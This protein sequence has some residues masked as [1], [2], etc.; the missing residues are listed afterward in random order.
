MQD[1]R[2]NLFFCFVIFAALGFGCAGIKRPWR[3]YSDKQFSSAEWLVGDKIERGRMVH[4]MFR[5]PAV[6]VGSQELAEKCLGK[7]DIKKTIDNREVWFYRVDIG[8]AG[9]MNLV[10][11]SFDDKGRGQIGYAHGGTMSIMAKEEEL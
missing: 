9:G 8:I 10:P 7:P 4:S 3:D 11:V 2:L 6:E 5:N 1:Q